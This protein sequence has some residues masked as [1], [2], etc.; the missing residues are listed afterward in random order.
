M[1]RII[2]VF[3][4]ITGGVFELVALS[5]VLYAIFFHEWVL[6]IVMAYVLMIA[7]CG[8]FYRQDK[9]QLRAERRYM[10]KHLTPS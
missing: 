6:S 2:L 1:S 8:I 5:V 9:R 3:L 10:E 4:F 7:L